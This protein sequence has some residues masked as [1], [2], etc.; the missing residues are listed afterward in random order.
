MSPP[1][2]QSHFKIG[3]KFDYSHRMIP[4]P[5]KAW[6]GGED[7]CF[8]H[9]NIL[10]VADGVGGWASRGVDPSAFSKKL[11]ELIYQNF[12]GTG[13]ARYIQD[14]ALLI[15]DSVAM[16]NELGTATVCVLVL[17]PSNGTL[18]SAHLGDSVFAVF[19]DGETLISAPEL[20]HQF[21]QPFQV[22][23]H[24]DDP[25]LSM[26][27]SEQMASGDT[28]VVGSD[29]VWDNLPRSS[30]QARAAGQGSLRTLADELAC[31]SY[32][33]S[34][35]KDYSSPFYEKAQANGVKCTKSGK[36]DDITVIAARVIQSITW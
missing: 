30:I 19:R 14:P 11:V 3:F 21:N 10:V 29:G 8:A 32:R 12:F 22:G 17:D 34:L 15:R 18:R 6:K 25:S 35:L 33:R 16:N 27:L 9:D 7:A 24:G 13:Q 31:E 1:N 20:Q 5:D 23:S 2:P 26:R 36:M 28:V 4:H